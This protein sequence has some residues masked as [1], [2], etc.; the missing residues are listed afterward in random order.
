MLEDYA[1]AVTQKNIWVLEGLGSE[2]L[3]VLVLVPETEYLLIENIAIKPRYQ[4]RGFGGELMD[5]AESE[6][7]KLGYKV[8]R[9]YTNVMMV[10]N[11]VIYEHLG[12]KVIGFVSEEGYDRVYMEKRVLVSVS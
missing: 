4:G 2:L 12:W 1:E 7:L 10:E 6:A 11:Q 3:G 8:M 5:F 9:L